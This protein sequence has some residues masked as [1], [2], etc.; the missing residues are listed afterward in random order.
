MVS[1]LSE[2]SGK[3]QTVSG[4]SSAVPVFPL[5]WSH[6]VRLLSVKNEDAGSSMNRRRCAAVGRFGN[7]TG[8]SQRYSTN[9]QSDR[10]E[11]SSPGS[12]QEEIRD[13]FV[14]EFVGLKDEYSESELEEALALHLEHSLLELG[15]DFAFVARQKGL[16][17]G[18]E[19]YR[20][21]HLFSHGRL[22]ALILIDLKLG[23]F[24]HVDAG[25]MGL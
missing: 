21:D 7:W 14:L 1:G 16:R 24:T 18:D 8:R 13:P 6:Y 11:N 15:N 17:V 3:V 5:S 19:W 10:T 4:Q 25:Q 9:A 12:A 23:K 20:I 22:R 2:T